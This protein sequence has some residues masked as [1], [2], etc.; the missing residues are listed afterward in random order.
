MRDKKKWSYLFS[1][2]RGRLHGLILQLSSDANV[3]VWPP[4]SQRPM[5]RRVS[6][7]SSNAFQTL[8]ITSILGCFSDFLSMLRLIKWEKIETAF[9]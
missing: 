2:A 5:I 9:N 6:Q 3:G 1:V 7:Q 8:N 4:G